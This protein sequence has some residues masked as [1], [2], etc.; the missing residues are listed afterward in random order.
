MQLEIAKLACENKVCLTL[1]E[2]VQYGM[3]ICHHVL[4]SGIG[5]HF[6]TDRAIYIIYL[7]IGPF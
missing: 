5:E 6:K 7:F 1:L 3:V 4:V 2:L